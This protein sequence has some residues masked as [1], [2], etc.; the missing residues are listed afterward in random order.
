V[1]GQGRIFYGEG[2]NTTDI[3]TVGLDAA[4]G[5]LAGAPHRV[6]KRF[7]GNTSS[8]MWSADGSRLAWFTL[9]RGRLRELV[10]RDLASGKESSLVVP[11]AA[12]DRPSPEW[13]RD[14]QILISKPVGMGTPPRGDDANLYRMDPAT[15]AVTPVRAPGYYW[16]R[17]GAKIYE[18]VG[19]AVIEVDAATRARKEVY[20]D[21]V[22]AYV[23]DVVPSPD[24]RSLALV[25]H[26][27]ASPGK[28][29]FYG[30]VHIKVVDLATGQ[31]REIVNVRPSWLRRMMAWTPDNRNLIYASEWYAGMD[32]PARLWIVPAAGGAPRQLGQDF[33][34]RVFGLSVSPDGKTLA[35]DES[36]NSSELMVM[37]GL[38]A[39]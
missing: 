12:Q 16:S 21:P 19:P 1:D 30:P 13:L 7:E 17:D 38:F 4:N 10:I 33:E 18:T 5:R 6:T 24:G 14:G 39:R 28:P 25:A 23:R 22:A 3:Y 26:Q 37:E 36:R 11:T 32:Q 29:D 20:R 15:G 31:G 2:T 34:G 35:F 8:P 9:D 27:N